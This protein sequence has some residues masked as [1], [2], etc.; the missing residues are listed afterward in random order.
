MH[1]IKPLDHEAILKSVSKTKCVVTAEEH[2]M[3]GGLGEAV[4]QVLS[5]NL[6]VPHEFVAVNDSFGESGA[7][8][9]LMT[10]Y[11]IDTANIISAVEK[12]IARKA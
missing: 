1:T 12:V 6:P 8:M 7:P 10:K 2:M 5:R 3:N 11:G 4:A 9:E